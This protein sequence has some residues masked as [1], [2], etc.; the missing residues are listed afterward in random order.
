MFVFLLDF[1]LVFDIINYTM[2]TSSWTKRPLYIASDHGGYQ[3]KKRLVRFI[4]NEL[5]LKVTDLGPKAYD[6]ND[7][8]PDYI[9]PAAE[10]TVKT[11]G[12][13]ILICGSG[14]G[15]CIAANKVKGMR[16]ALA[17]NI[18]S[19]ELSR[20]HNDANGLCLAGRVLTEEHAMAIVKKWLETEEF[21]G[22]K[23]QR[24]NE[25]ISSFENSS[26]S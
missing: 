7:D 17:Y 8:F 9:I 18:E 22:G 21:L 20:K 12:R 25:K 3:L 24:R 11:N 1:K 15:S 4:K 19:A 16:A 2:E 13:A 10:K 5:Q 26:P 14:I 23:Y 6:E